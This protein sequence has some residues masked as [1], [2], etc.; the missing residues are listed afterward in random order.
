MNKNNKLSKI[1]NHNKILIAL[2]ILL[3]KCLLRIHLIPNKVKTIVKMKIKN[4]NRAH[5]AV[6]NVHKN[7][8][9]QFRKMK[10]NKSKR[11]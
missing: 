7:N 8:K 1:A 11:S 4:Q 6:F 2:Q 10:K 9:K 5:K 3:H